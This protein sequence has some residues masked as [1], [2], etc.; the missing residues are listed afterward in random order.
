MYACY[1]QKYVGRM[2]GKSGSGYGRIQA[3]GNSGVR[4]VANQYNNYN[5]RIIISKYK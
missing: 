5:N 2:L 3:V 4:A 1:L